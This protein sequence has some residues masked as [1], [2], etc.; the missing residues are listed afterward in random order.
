MNIIWLFHV[1][2]FFEKMD[3]IFDSDAH[4]PL[5]LVPHESGM[6]GTEL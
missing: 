4:F 1:K 3:I 5:S 6:S 2:W